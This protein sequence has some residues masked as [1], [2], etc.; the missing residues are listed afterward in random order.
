MMPMGNARPRARANRFPEDDVNSFWTNSI[1]RVQIPINASEPAIATEVTVETVDVV[2]VEIIAFLLVRPG[3]IT[4]T[5]TG[6][7]PETQ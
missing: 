6:R 3:R 7:K 1:K 2:T 4:E 5:V